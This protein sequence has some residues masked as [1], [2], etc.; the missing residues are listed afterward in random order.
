MKILQVS[1]APYG[2]V[3]EF[4]L[5]EEIARAFPPPDHQFTYCT[6]TGEPDPDIERRSGCQ[7]VA[8]RL[9]AKQVR[10][11]RLRTLR[12][13]I[14][15]LRDGQYDLIITHRFKPWLLF[16]LASRFIPKETPILAV[17]H[18]YH[19]FRRRRRQWLARSL[20]GRDCV[21]VA[22]SNAIRED[23]V[24]HGIP[25]PRI[26]VIPNAIDIDGI[27]QRQLS[28]ELARQA[29]GLKDDAIVIGTIGR[30]RPVKGHTYLLDAFYRVAGLSPRLCLVIIGGGELEK[31]LQ[32]KSE[33]LGL[34]G[35]VIISGELPNAYRY[36]PAVDIFTMTSLSEGLPMAVLEAMATHLPVIGTRVGGIPEALGDTALLVPE[37]DPDALA[38][39]LRTALNWEETQ[40]R[41]YVNSQSRRLDRHFT[42]DAY[43]ENY[44]QLAKKIVGKRS[45]R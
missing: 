9:N 11:T 24:R 32:R 2:F 4:D 27:R 41:D 40:R 36:L 12:M 25:E 31:D 19:Q 39:A 22:V 15:L 44:L 28:R 10:A 17:F 18:A 16:S 5:Y 37:A 42:I 8:L 23:L 34:S 21:Y 3:S 30:L 33:A 7:L 13:I 20:Q 1:Y 45:A 6:L 35:R 29:L 43:R 14:G 38:D 26:E